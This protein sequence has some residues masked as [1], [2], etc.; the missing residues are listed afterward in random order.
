MGRPVRVAE[1]MD[2]LKASSSSRESSKS[3]QAEGDQ[4]WSQGLGSRGRPEAA[5]PVWKAALDQWWA[6][7]VPV[8]LARTGFNST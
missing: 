2:L 1:R 3:L 4:S 7:A 6:V 8:R 5:A